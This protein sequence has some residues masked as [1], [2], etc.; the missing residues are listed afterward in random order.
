MIATT[1]TGEDIEVNSNIF[2]DASSSSFK[3]T[4]KPYEYTGSVSGYVSGG[5]SPVATVN[6]IEK[7][8]FAADGNASDVGDLTQGRTYSAGQSS[9][10]SG[11]TSGGFAPPH[12][13]TI[14][15]FPFAID[16][17]ATDVGDL[18]AVR[19]LLA[20]QS[21]RTSGYTSGG[22]DSSL[23]PYLFNTID[24]FSFSSNGNATDVGD[25]TQSRYGSSGQ[26]SAPSGY[27]SG[28]GIAPPATPTY[29]N[30]IDKFSFATDGN[31]TDVGDL[32][33]SRSYLVGQNS[34]VSGYASGGITPSLSN[35]ID[36]FPFSSDSNATDVGDLTATKW[37]IAGQSSTASG[38]SS[39]GVTPAPTSV[40]DKFP[41]SSDANATDVG[42]LTAARITA[43]GQQV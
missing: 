33:Q 4:L 11:Y 15:K 5:Q 41:F 43:T 9:S 35:T 14:D 17:N 39:G 40:I 32:T 30:T 37:G 1:Y 6:I 10:V 13:N 38:Y 12:V 8:P 20:G 25:L 23:T 34:S 31:A 16:T 42:D 26:S 29:Q 7:F 18:T 27:S 19:R 3:A 22:F 24:K 36:K 28:G 2:Y 21:S